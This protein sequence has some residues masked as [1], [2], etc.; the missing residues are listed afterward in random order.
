LQ[1]VISAIN[2]SFIKK[3]D[4]PQQGSTKLKKIEIVWILQAITLKWY[5][6]CWNGFIILLLLKL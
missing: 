4:L 1:Y 5:V 2:L 3:I 6:I